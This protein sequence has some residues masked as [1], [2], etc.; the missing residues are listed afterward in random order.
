MDLGV[1]AMRSGLVRSGEFGDAAAAASS[2]S[3][4][5]INEGDEKVKLA[6]LLPGVARWT[7]L[8][9]NGVPNEI[10]EVSILVFCVSLFLVSYGY[11]LGLCGVTRGCWV[12][13]NCI[14][15]V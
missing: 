12:F 5:G 11:G 6:A 13:C 4:V 8:A 9:L 14:V 10:I 1:G 15:L 7:H 3:G 2:G